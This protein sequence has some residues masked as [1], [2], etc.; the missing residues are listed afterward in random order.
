MC[1][2]RKGAN[3]EAAAQKFRLLFQ[4][5]VA[6]GCIM[7]AAEV[8]EELI[9]VEDLARVTKLTPDAIYKKVRKREIPAIKIGRDLRFVPSVISAWLG[10]QTIGSV[11]P[12]ESHGVRAGRRTGKRDIR[13]LITRHTSK[14]ESKPTQ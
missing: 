9:T 14:P 12:S 10:S 7:G 11:S 6:R 4:G 8:L 3:R 2:A 1:G 13:S 5:H